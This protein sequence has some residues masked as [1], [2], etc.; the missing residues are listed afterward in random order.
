MKVL[1]L[2]VCA[3]LVVAAGAQSCAPVS[4]GLL[5]LGDLSV[6][7]QS[8]PYTVPPVQAAEIEG[9]C[10]TARLWADAAKYAHALSRLTPIACDIPA[11]AI[12]FKSASPDAP[13][14]DANVLNFIANGECLEAIFDSYAVRLR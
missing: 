11:A 6:N 9:G 8:G 5:P 13:I 1:A 7:D 10:Q 12:A 14:T 4:Q 3:A 2:L